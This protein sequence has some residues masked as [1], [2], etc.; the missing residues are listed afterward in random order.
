MSPVFYSAL[1]TSNPSVGI[2]S[3]E[4]VV[5]GHLL[6]LADY[7]LLEVRLLVVSIWGM[8]VDRVGR[9]A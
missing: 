7:L 6:Y 5:P 3:A 1:T 8:G 2:Q 9:L 4:R